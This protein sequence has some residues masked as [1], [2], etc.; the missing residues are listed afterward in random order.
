MVYTNNWRMDVGEDR[1]ASSGTPG[2]ASPPKRLN[3]PGDNAGAAAAI[4][5]L[6]RL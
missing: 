4:A 6:G 3:A 2:G 5:S 1:K